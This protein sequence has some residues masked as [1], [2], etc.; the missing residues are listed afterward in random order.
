MDYVTYQKLLEMSS[1]ENGNFLEHVLLQDYTDRTLIYG[2]TCDRD[3]F[4]IYLEGGEVCGCIYGFKAEEV[5][6]LDLKTLEQCIPNK[7]VYPHGCD[8][9]FCEM[10]IS[11]GIYIPFT[12][13]SVQS[14]LKFE[15]SGNVYWGR[16]IGET[17]C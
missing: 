3:T 6:P 15:Q 9:E 7:R 10:L 12:T 13:F 1:P 16:I 11:R 17:I 5:T 4:H 8:L 14:L 2:Y